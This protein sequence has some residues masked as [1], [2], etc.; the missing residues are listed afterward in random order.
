M[1]ENPKLNK[2]KLTI[3]RALI[4]VFDKTDLVMLG[5]ALENL[6]IEILSTGGSAKILRSEGIKVQLTP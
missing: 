4:S 1:L 6:N 2:N 3:R 5:S